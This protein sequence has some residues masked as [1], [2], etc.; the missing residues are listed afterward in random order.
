MIS[1]PFKILSWSEYQRN[2][3]MDKLLKKQTFSKILQT[4]PFFFE[5]LLINVFHVTEVKK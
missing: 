3:N 5:V 1:D 4:D 2:L